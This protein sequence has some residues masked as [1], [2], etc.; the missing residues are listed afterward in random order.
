MI[1]SV[2]RAYELVGERGENMYS[3]CKAN[4]LP[5]STINEHRLNGTQLKVDTIYEFCDAF[6][7]TISKFFEEEE[8]DGQQPPE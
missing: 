1:N 2:E 6:G 7:I 5:Y 8:K 3:F 4:R